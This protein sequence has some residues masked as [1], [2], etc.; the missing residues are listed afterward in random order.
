MT[1]IQ[2]LELHC[3][4]SN[5][6]NSKEFSHANSTIPLEAALDEG[7]CLLRQTEV[8][9]HYLWEPDNDVVGNVHHI[10]N[11]VESLSKF[12]FICS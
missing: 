2:F 7:H 9:T 8:C 10:M 12:L 3:I 11:I 4:S 6:T 5:F 1:L